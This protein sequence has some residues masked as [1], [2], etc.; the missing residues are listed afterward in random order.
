MRISVSDQGIGVSPEA[1]ERIFNP[2][3]Q[4]DASTSKYYGGTG[5]GL[6]IT[7]R[8]VEIMGG[9]IT[10]ES[11]PGRGSTFHC[12][13]LLAKD[14]RNL[15]E[16]TWPGLAGQKVIV[17]D[18]NERNREMLSGFLGNRGMEPFPAGTGPE[19]I[20]CLNTLAEGHDS[21][22]VLLLDPRCLDEAVAET[23]AGL[24]THPTLLVKTVAL[25]TIGSGSPEMRH[26]LPGLER[27][28]AK[29]IV[30]SE[31]LK[32][33]GQIVAG[34]AESSESADQQT[35][36]TERSG[37]IRQILVADDMEVNRQL[38]SVI[39]ERQGHR[40]TLVENGRHAIEAFA[41]GRFDLVLMDVQMPGMD[42][43][44]ATRRIRSLEAN[45]GGR[46]PILALTAY[47]TADDRKK[48]LDAGM[49]GYLSKPFKPVELLALLDTYACPLQDE[50]KFPQNKNTVST[51]TDTETPA[52]DQAGLLSRLGGREDLLERFVGMFLKGVTERF[53]QLRRSVTDNDGE[54]LKNLAHS[55]KGMAANIGAERVRK[56]VERLEDQGCNDTVAVAETFLPELKQELE[57]F[58][59][60]AEGQDYKPLP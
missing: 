5:L 8:L 32:T 52:F 27:Y 29:P 22:V 15:P 11:E 4:A 60:A 43:L 48:C 14:V 44:E 47:A 34:T 26:K 7:K 39:L 16:Q 9:S 42:G 28:L 3:E 55:I 57:S 2:F 51:A 30:Y 40:V 45:R 37:A 49:D 46:T 58:R 20:S 19:L 59:A 35:E 10:V 54:S 21:L 53:E 23:L 38:S 36:A 13:V 33:I 18:R 25:Y 6:T 56:L 24:S 17:A 1:L 12:T 31:L 50:A 41:G